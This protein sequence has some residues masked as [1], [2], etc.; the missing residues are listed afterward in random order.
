MHSLGWSVVVGLV[1]LFLSGHAFAATQTEFGRYHALVIGNNAYQNLSPLE[2]A[3]NDATV[4]AEVLQ[5]QYGYDVTLLLNATRY[6]IVSEFSRLRR[7]LTPNDNLL[8]Y[9]AGHGY[10]DELAD[11][12]YWLPIDA[13]A[14]N[15]A[16]WVANDTI[17]NA[18]KTIP[19]RHV[20]VV[21]DSCYSGSLARAAEIDLRQGM[22]RDEWLKRMAQKR[23]RTV[24]ASG[25]LEPV[26]DSG[27]GEHSIFAR[28]FI[29]VLRASNQI[30]DG[31]GLFDRIKNRVVMN[32]DQTPRYDNIHKAG[33]EEGDFL[34][35]PLNVEIA[36]TVSTPPQKSNTNAT[37]D[38]LFWQTIKDSDEP[39]V[40]QA[41]LD[42]FPN[43]TFRALARLKIDRAV[44]KPS[45]PEVLKPKTS[46]P[47]I[48]ISET[49]LEMMVLKRANVRAGPATTFEK[50][51]TLPAGA[52]VTVTGK[53]EEAEWYR[54]DLGGS[55]TGYV[56]APLVGEHDRA[57]LAESYGDIASLAGRKIWVTSEVAFADDYCAKLRRAGL[58]VE[59]DEYFGAIHDQTTIELNCIEIP[60]GAVEAIADYL[61]LAAYRRDPAD[62]R[63]RP[64]QQGELRSCGGIGEIVL[65]YV[66]VDSGTSGA[67]MAGLAGHKIW[68]KSEAAFGD[69]YCARL[70]SAG[71]IVECDE[72]FGVVHDAT[73]IELNCLDVPENAVETIAGYL[74]L[75]DYR[76]DPNDYR[77]QPDKQSEMRGCAGIGE[78]VLEIMPPN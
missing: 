16:N 1:A 19:A 30:L 75:Q 7:E 8:I 39:A 17:T 15:Q 18:V 46:S 38:A 51:M 25:G 34:F 22:E 43:G 6:Q 55:Q 54:I 23:S 70:R 44:T 62:Y 78:I 13:E 3:E 53:V 67:D 2:T 63:D 33:H 27:G 47:S 48:G 64:D 74:A 9:Y 49:D 56:Y 4:V 28:N 52:E 12:G 20:L 65:E 35:V 36:V 24:L 60:E 11:A 58:T 57:P 66:P 21:A 29:D 68:V 73:T 77:D 61:G 76:R 14:D 45:E 71:M 26:M 59:C 40:Y 10:L 5:Q 31:Q 41:Y 42:Q 50:I 37:M 32:A 69:D 72:Y